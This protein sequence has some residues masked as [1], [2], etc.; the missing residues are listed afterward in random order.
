MQPVLGCHAFFR[1]RVGKAVK[2]KA[3]ELQVQQQQRRES[4][5]VNITIE[6]YAGIVLQRHP[7]KAFDTDPLDMS[8]LNSPLSGATVVHTAMIVTWSMMKTQ[9]TGMTFHF[10]LHLRLKI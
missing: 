5:R 6:L 4:K 3:R 10:H 2:E 7:D 8:P 1:N 9:Q